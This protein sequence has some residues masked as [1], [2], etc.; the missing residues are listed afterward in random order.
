V[1]GIL[2]CK[3]YDILSPAL[4]MEEDKMHYY[5]SIWFSLLSPI[6]VQVTAVTGTVRAK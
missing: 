6:P 2:I 4:T 1:E 5:K 3:E